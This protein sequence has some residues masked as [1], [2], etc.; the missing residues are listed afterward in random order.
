MPKNKDK[1]QYS[2]DNAYQTEEVETESYKPRIKLSTDSFLGV[3]LRGEF[4]TSVLQHLDYTGL[5]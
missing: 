5:V 2:S 3:K 4:I 1:F